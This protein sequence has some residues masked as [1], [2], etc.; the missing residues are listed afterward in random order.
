MDK[1][2]KALERDYQKF[3][4]GRATPAILE[5]LSANYYGTATPLSQMASISVPDPRTLL[6]Q[7]WDQSILPEIEKS[8]LK[9]DLGLTP[10]NDGKV[11]RINIPV[12]SAERRKELKKLVNK[13]GEE[14]KIALRTVRRDANEQI[15]ELKNS[16]EISEDQQAKAETQVQKITNEFVSKVDQVSAAKEKEIMEF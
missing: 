7:P 16:K 12:L 8:I 10:Q 3:R 4:T 9:S 13:T 14:A 11:I 1:T 6:L 5:G 15:K 2:L